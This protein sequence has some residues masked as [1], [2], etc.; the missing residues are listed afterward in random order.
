MAGRPAHARVA[1]GEATRPAWD[2]T[3]PL[4]E[5]K[6]QGSWESQGP[7]V[8]DLWSDDPSQDYL[9]VD[10]NDTWSE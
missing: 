7:G 8:Y 6:A 2:E 3:P 1:A 9:G 4:I 5:D 10:Q